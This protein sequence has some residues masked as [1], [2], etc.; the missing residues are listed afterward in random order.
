MLLGVTK[1]PREA[2]AEA[3]ETTQKAIQVGGD[4]TV[5]HGTVN[6]HPLRACRSTDH[7]PKGPCPISDSKWHEHTEIR[8]SVY[9]IHVS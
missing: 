5:A 9:E 2:L 1:D 6:L 8:F 3:I 4:S 7:R